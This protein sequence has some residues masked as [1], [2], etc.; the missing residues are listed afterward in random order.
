MRGDLY[1]P[2]K[3][4]RRPCEY[5][6]V[7]NDLNSANGRRVSMIR[8][9]RLTPGTPIEHLDNT[10]LSAT[11][12]SFSIRKQCQRQNFVVKVLRNPIDIAF[13]KI[14]PGNAPITTGGN[15]KVGVRRMRQKAADVV[16]MF[17]EIV[18]GFLAAAAKVP[19]ANSTVFIPGEKSGASFG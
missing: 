1:N 15:K 8:P 11:E 18:H 14:P 12:E 6:V 3:A 4:V 9:Y 5:G 7:I 16:V 13:A 2:N 19:N 17:V 10:V